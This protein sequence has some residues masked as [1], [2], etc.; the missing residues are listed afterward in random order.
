MVDYP[1][2]CQLPNEESWTIVKFDLKVDE[3]KGTHVEVWNKEAG[4][5][6]L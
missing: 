6:N 4:L 1:N 2:E 3:N 5:D